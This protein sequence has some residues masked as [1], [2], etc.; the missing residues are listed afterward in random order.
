L[1]I[2][3]PNNFIPERTYIINV[4]VSY[5]LGIKYQMVFDKT[6]SDYHFILENGAEL[7]IKDSFFSKIKGSNY[8]NIENLPQAPIFS[9]NPFSSEE[10][11]IILYG[12]EFLSHSR[13]KIICGNDIF[14]ASFFMLTRWEEFVIKDKDQFGRFP[15]EKSYVMIHNLNLRPIVN[16]YTEMLWRIFQYLGCKQKRKFRAYKLKITHD[17]DLFTK[18]STIGKSFKTIAGDIL[19]RKN[20]N[21]ATQNFK[22]YLKIRLGKNKDPYNVFDFFMDVSEKHQLKSHFYFI[23]AK[24]D[25]K[26]T[27]YSINNKNVIETIE[28]IKKREHII[29]YHASWNTFLNYS[30]FIDEIE[31]LEKISGKIEEGRQ[32]YL[33]FQ[34]P[35]TWQDWEK[36]GRR[37]ESTLGFS[38]NIGFRCGTCYLFPVFDILERKK[39]R[40]R[41]NPLI[42]MDTALKIVYSNQNQMLKAITEIGQIVQKYNGNLVLLWHNNT[43]NDYDWENYEKFYKEMIQILVAPEK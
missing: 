14:A 29:G 21:L 1:I 24:V 8:L 9:E 22:N 41:E 23:P 15:E 19:V 27:T 37:E 34:I 10:D 28:N 31:T 16:E 42:L 2:K 43:I 39:L 18:Y 38:K 35:D 6:I 36:S 4:L 26:E 30:N 12:D 17:I 5:F 25:E 20:L 13:N 33:R 11:S 32:H 3:I 7:I 40:L